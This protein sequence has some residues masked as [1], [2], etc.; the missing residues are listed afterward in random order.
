MIYKLNPEFRN[1]PFV[2]GSLHCNTVIKE[3]VG[4]R[5]TVGCNIC[6]KQITRR[7]IYT[8]FSDHFSE[9]ILTEQQVRKLIL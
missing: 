9:G 4:N 5:K 1:D 3:I 8:H 2:A 6:N 7:K